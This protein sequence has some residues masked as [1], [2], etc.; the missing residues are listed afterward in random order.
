VNRDELQ[1]DAQPSIHFPT[2][3]ADDA[4]SIEPHQHVSLGGRLKKKAPPE[5]LPWFDHWRGA[6]GPALRS[7]LATIRETLD[8]HEKAE[9][10]RQKARRPDDQRR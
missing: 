1:D 3:D 8:E 5:R 10:Q 4:V 6:Q 9:G 7:L 2:A